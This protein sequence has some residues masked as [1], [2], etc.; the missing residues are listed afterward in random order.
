MLK[1]EPNQHIY[2]IESYYVKISEQLLHSNNCYGNRYERRAIQNNTKEK[3][4]KRERERIISS[5]I[6][7]FADGFKI[8]E[9][10]NK[11]QDN[12]K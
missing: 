8:P 7:R 10:M 5:K 12:K 2:A 3:K 6:S 1:L 11:R 9:D 4:K